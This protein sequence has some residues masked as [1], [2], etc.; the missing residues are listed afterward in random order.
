MLKMLRI[1]DE[2]AKDVEDVKDARAPDLHRIAKY[3]I[4]LTLLEPLTHY[5]K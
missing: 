4:C 3:A 5:E 2:G 1:L